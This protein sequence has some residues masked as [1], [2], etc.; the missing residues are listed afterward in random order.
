MWPLVVNLTVF[1]TL[2]FGLVLVGDAVFPLAVLWALWHVLKIA[3]PRERQMY[4]ILVIAGLIMD[5]ILTVAGVY[6]FDAFVLPVL[7]LWMLGLWLVFPTI[8][9]HGIRWVWRGSPLFL[10]LGSVGAASTYVV[11]ANIA[12][13]NLP[14]GAGITFVVVTA[15]WIGYF[16][17]TRALL[18]TV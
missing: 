12:P 7:P 8:L 2:W 11:G 14:L 3:T 9:N 18:K 16:S 1:Q 4:P 6:Q 10:V 15:I 17:L 5:E 13:L